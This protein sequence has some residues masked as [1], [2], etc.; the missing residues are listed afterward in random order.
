MST[1]R[2]VMCAI[3]C[4]FS[5]G[6][7]LYLPEFQEFPGDKADGQLLV[8]SIVYNVTCEAQDAIDKVYN[9]P[10]H[11]VESTF[12]DSWGINIALNL[13]I[14]EKS[15]VNPNATWL[16]LSP[17]NAVFTLNGGL[18]ASADATRQDKLNSYFTVAELRKLGPC[19]PR[20]RPGGVLL[21]QSDLGL[22][23]W[24][25]SN[26]TAAN[27][28]DINYRQFKAD[29]PL[30]Q[31]VLSHEIK[32]DITNSGN[33]TPAWKLTRVLVNPSGNLFSATRDRTSD[34]TMTLGPAV[35]TAKVVHDKN[36]KPKTVVSFA[37]SREAAD[38]A[39]AS[40]IGLAVANA[41]RGSL[42][43]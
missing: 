41:L 24:L 2:I 22:A 13:Q 21:L 38:A 33:L 29:G 1:M 20:T 18:N 27:T 8:Q 6:C 36:G 3:S 10:D 14:E 7:G 15:S 25:Y 9:N 43:Q 5:G 16:P 32:F 35:A 4:A 42:Q 31:N 39:L 30:K 26:L 23:E 28:G 11:P 12:L 19:N 40:Q 37:P 17:A 34:L